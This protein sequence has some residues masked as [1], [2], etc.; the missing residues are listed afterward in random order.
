MAIITQEQLCDYLGVEAS[1]RTSMIVSATNAWVEAYTNR[2][3]GESVQITETH[4]YAPVIF[5][6]EA[7]IKSIDE[8][9]VNDVLAN[10]DELKI[11]KTTG[12]VRITCYGEQK[13]GRNYFDAIVVKYTVGTDT[14]PSDLILATLQ[15]ASDNYNRNDK[16][17]GNITSESVGG[18]SKSYGR[19][20]VT[21]SGSVISASNP[22][23]YM[24]V[25]N[26]YR[27]IHL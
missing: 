2:H 11:D 4:D 14:V 9:T 15:L 26:F 19:A 25:F 1:D 16:A 5:L 12:R 8:I 23:D 22:N 13:Y 17:E 27:R 20:S 10:L 3:F 6:N 18:Y 21:S 24:N 7:D